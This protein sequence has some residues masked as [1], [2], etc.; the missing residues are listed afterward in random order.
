M[1]K[2]AVIVKLPLKEGT[3]DQLFSA[4]EPMLEHVN[5]E[6]GTEIYILHADA[7]D[8]NVAWVYELYTDGD[9]MAAHSGSEVMAAMLGTLGD[10]LDGAPEFNMATPHAGKGL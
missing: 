3:R 6:A 1:S 10:L 9:A 2:T 5:S 4:F 8:E 7:G